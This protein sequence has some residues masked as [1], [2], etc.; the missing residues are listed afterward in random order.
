MLGHV[1]GEIMWLGRQ[2]III[3][4]EIEIDWGLI[5]SLLENFLCSLVKYDRL[6]CGH[7]KAKLFSILERYSH[8]GKSYKV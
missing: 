6:R 2:T 1:T 5:S 7:Y 3:G 8:C 4:E